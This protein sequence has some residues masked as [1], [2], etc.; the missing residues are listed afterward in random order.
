MK[1]LAA[2]VILFLTTPAPSSAQSFSEFLSGVRSAPDSLTATQIVNE[3][4]SRHSAPV[5]ENDRICF[6][7]RG[8]GRVA[9]VPGDMNGWNPSEGMMARLERTNLFFRSESLAA[10]GRLE[11]KIWVDSAWSLDPLN[12][13]TSLGGFGL[14]SEVRMPSYRPSV[15]AVA[16]PVISHGSLDTLWVESASL[17]RKHPVFVYLPPHLK[18]DELLPYIFVTDGSDYLSIGKMNVVLDNLIAGR[19]ITPVIALFIDPKTDIADPSTN[20]RMTEYGASDAYLDFLEKELLPAVQQRFP[21]SRQH[22]NSV[23]LGASMGGLIST[24]ASL[25]RPEVFP[26]CASQSPAYRQADSAVIKL[27]DTLPHLSA[28]IYIQ[29]GLIRDTQA[30]AK[31]VYTKLRIAG[32]NI[33]YEEFPE[34]HNWTNWMAHVPKMLEYYFG[35]R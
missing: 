4:M 7:Y 20:Q 11:Y 17:H 3:Y 25:M 21:I 23:I 28:R 19:K 27:A 24:Y 5:V 26:N 31:H 12:Q 6:L 29:T 8:E 34:G 14:N 18:K 22:T 2:I 33:R 32:A 30:E 10:N 16:N 15:W 9:A 13:K 1:F 35:K